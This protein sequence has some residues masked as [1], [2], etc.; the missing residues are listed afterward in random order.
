MAGNRYT[1]QTITRHLLALVYTVAGILHIIWPAPF[2]SITPAWVPWPNIIILLTGICE[3]AGA[4][5]LYN[6]TFRRAAGIALAV[7]AVAVFP[8][9]INHAVLDLG[10]AQPV[11]GPWY[12]IPRLAFQPVLVWAALFAGRVTS[13]PYR[14]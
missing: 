4:I 2:L 11:L 14:R 12:H 6:I 9:N 3:I 10:L 13:F 1:S 8:A 5:A 7:Y